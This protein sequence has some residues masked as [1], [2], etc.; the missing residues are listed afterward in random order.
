MVPRF[1]KA[2]ITSSREARSSS[3]LQGARLELKST[4][5]NEQKIIQAK[6]GY[7]I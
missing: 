1:P 4:M 3:G 2:R 6:F 5:I 7:R